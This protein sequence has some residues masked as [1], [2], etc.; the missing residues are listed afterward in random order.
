MGTPTLDRRSTVIAALATALGCHGADKPAPSGA[1]ASAATGVA[2]APSDETPAAPTRCKASGGTASVLGTIT[3]D[4]FGFDGDG[5]VLYYSSWEIYGQRGDVGPVR[6]DG[7]GA[8]KLAS[9]DLEPRGLAVDD[10]AVYYTSGIRLM[11]IPKAGGE[12]KTIA[13]QFSAQHIAV[14][15]GDVFGVPGDYGPYDRVAR[16]PKNGGDTKELSTAKRP[17]SPTPPNGFSALRVDDSGVFVT[18][19]GNGRVLRFPLDGGA[20][21]ILAAHQDKVFD[22]ALAGPMLYFDLARKGELYTA[23]SAG[24]T[25]KKVASGLVEEARIAGDD[26]AVFATVAA[27]KDGDAAAF[28]RIA[29]ESGEV[30]KL[31][32]VPSTQSVS[33]V[34]LDADCVYWVVRETSSKSVVYARHR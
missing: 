6:K 4:V 13:P 24:G 25:P 1:T 3:G 33:R 32:D 30:T 7:G 22:L 17:P 23:S 10:T 20:S 29:P 18:D 31:A 2:S 14:H 26:R 12:A 16:I 11:S 5:T 34:A 8:S 15:G 21:K 27:K 9:L 19:S 28:S